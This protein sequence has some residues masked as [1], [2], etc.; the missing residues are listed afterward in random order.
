MTQL[1]TLDFPYASTID[2]PAV[3]DKAIQNYD[4]SQVIVNAVLPIYNAMWELYLMYELQPMSSMFASTIA[5]TFSKLC[6]ERAIT[7]GLQI[8]SVDI[9]IDIM[10]TQLKCIVVHKNYDYEVVMR[11]VETSA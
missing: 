4:Y 8:C 5:N 11:F 10:A 7:T 9:P 1:I 2:I 3:P 6:G